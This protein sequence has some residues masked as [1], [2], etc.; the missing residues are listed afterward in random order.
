MLDQVRRT[1]PPPWL[2]WMG[3]PDVLRPASSGWSRVAA[4]PRALAASGLAPLSWIERNIGTLIDAES[5]ARLDGDALVHLDVRSDNI[6]FAADGPKL[7]DWS[8]ARLG[9]PFLDQHYWATTLHRETG[10]R[11]DWLLGDGA[12]EHLTVVAGYYAGAIYDPAHLGVRSVF[13]TTRELALRWLL[14]WVCDL[15]G[16]DPPDQSVE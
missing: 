5:R 15:V 14:P 9:H 12:A 11:P 16:I 8:A 7:I 2:V 1:D 6:C 3:G 4:R 10:N 13:D